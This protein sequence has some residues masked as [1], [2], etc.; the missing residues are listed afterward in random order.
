MRSMSIFL[1]GIAVVSLGCSRNNLPMQTLD[2]AGV[3]R[4][5]FLHAP[6]AHDG[7]SN[8]PLLFNFHG[9]GGT[10]SSQLDWA[11]FRSLADEHGF[12]VVYPQGT[13]MSG[14]THW[15][16]GLPG[17][18]NKSTAD[19]FGFVLALIDHIAASYNVDSDRIYATGYSNGGFLSYS[20]ACYYSD[21]LRV[22]PPYRRPC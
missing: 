11:D 20:L 21:V 22:S 14:S 4:E 1:F 17:G 8:L 16:S 9:F 6:A 7:A 12:L 13:E 2:H 3:E 10:A 18:D 15:N 19:D 5:Y